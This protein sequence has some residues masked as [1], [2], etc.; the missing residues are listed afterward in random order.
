MAKKKA[1]TKKKPKKPEPWQRMNR[2]PRSK[3]DAVERVFLESGGTNLNEIS[4]QTG[5]S[6]NAVKR[7]IVERKLDSRLKRTEAR[8]AEIVDDRLSQRSAEKKL[9]A[10]QTFEA[11]V[12]T[13]ATRHVSLAREVQLLESQVEAAE[14]FLAGY[15]ETPKGERTQEQ[16]SRAVGYRKMLPGL[17]VELRERG[18]FYLRQ[19][20]PREI[21]ELDKYV[22]ELADPD[23]ITT[24]Q[25]R[26]IIRGIIASV[27]AHCS[28]EEQ[29]A[30]AVEC[31]ALLRAVKNAQNLMGGDA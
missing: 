2:L 27:M 18:D 6:W 31:T 30:I 22:R 29:G 26:E 23:Q 16:I 5:V 25:V 20:P 4:R 11:M 19:M 21:R 24:A 7:V 8:E 1:Q 12:A 17:R 14:A 13:S 28:P 3:A 15:D 9:R 10:I